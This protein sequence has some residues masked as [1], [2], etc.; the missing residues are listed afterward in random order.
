M[1]TSC[2]ECCTT[3]SVGDEAK[4]K[5]AR[6]PHCKSVFVAR[7]YI[8]PELVDEETEF[9]A[10]DVEIAESNEDANWSFG[11]PALLGDIKPRATVDFETR[12]VKALAAMRSAAN[13]MLAA[14]LLTTFQFIL[15]VSATVYL[16][17]LRIHDGLRNER[18]ADLTE[19]LVGA[20]LGIL[21]LGLARFFVGLAVPKL[22]QAGSRGVIINGIVFDLLLMLEYLL[23]LCPCIYSLYVLFVDPNP[24]DRFSREIGQ[25]RVG[26]FALIIGVWSQFVLIVA[27]VGLFA[28]IRAIYAL[29]NKDVQNYYYQLRTRDAKRRRLLED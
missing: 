6:C 13:W 22:Y 10:M 21:V 18:L 5:K 15:N 16:W 29:R 7:P 20:C 12:H 2:T 19:P 3:L 14:F 23:A 17:Y 9:P 1:L 11:K 26:T 8:E 25:G 24:G 4:G 27:V 28:A